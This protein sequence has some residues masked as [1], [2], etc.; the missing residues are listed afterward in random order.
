MRNEKKMMTNLP[1]WEIKMPRIPAFRL[2][3]LMNL[4]P[5]ENVGNMPNH[6]TKLGLKLSKI[7]DAE[8]SLKMGT[9][10]AHNSETCD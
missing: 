7:T 8:K 9:K 1:R 5:L 6:I 10:I 4:K 2:K 3:I